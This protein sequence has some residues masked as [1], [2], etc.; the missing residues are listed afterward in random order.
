MSYWVRGWLAAVTSL[1][2]WVVGSAGFFLLAMVLGP[3]LPVNRSRSVG[4]TLLHWVF[5]GYVAVLRW[6]GVVRCEF[7]GFEQLEQAPTGIIIAPN[8]PAIWDAVFIIGRLSSLTCIVKSS[9]LR[10]PFMTGGLKLARFIPN[11]PPHE[12]VKRC[13]HALQHGERL[14]LFPEGTRTRTSEGVVNEFRGGI[15]LVAKH[16]GAPV[17]PVFVRTTGTYGRKGEAVWRPPAAPVTITMTVGQPVQCGEQ[18]N[19]HEFLDRLREPFI[20]ALSAPPDEVVHPDP[21]L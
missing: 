18:E 8:H 15:A 5:A 3:L 2:Y 6:F 13:V 11:D 10:N 9:L 1:V 20:E 14:L 16:S 12:M 19:A 21:Q 7:V 17:W 4:Q